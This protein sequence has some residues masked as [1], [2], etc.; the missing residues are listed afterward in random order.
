MALM[1]HIL[2]KITAR[3][4]FPTKFP[5]RKSDFGKTLRRVLEFPGKILFLI[6]FAILLPFNIFAASFA[7]LKICPL[8]VNPIIVFEIGTGLSFFFKKTI[9]RYSKYIKGILING[10]NQC[11][12]AWQLDY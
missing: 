1:T 3:L 7:S 11:D 12:H 2:N 10:V 9:P 4:L 8:S 6:P 5:F